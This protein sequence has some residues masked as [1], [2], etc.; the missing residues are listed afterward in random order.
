[1]TGLERP[2]ALA[3]LN[4]FVGE[5]SLEARFP[6]SA[7]E[8]GPRA[9]TTF[10][11]LLDGQFLAQR[12]DVPVPEAPDSLTIVCVDPQTGGYTQHYYDSRGVARR[13]AMSFDGG[14]WQLVRDSP[15][16]SPLDFCQ[17]FTGTFSDDQAT[18]DGAWEKSSNGTTWVHDFGLTYRRIG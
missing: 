2:D 1:M 17:R 14:T 9:R 13:Y 12:T 15:D 18:I 16:F 4:I 11:W 10:E 8:T 3:H 5:W 7:D 6:G